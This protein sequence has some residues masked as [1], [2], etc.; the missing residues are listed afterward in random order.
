MTWVWAH[1]PYSGERLLL[2][3]ALADYANDEGICFPSHGTLARKARCSQGWVS[4]TI[5]Q[6]IGDGLLEVV[7]KAG[8][9]RGKVGRYRLLIGLTECDLSEQIGLTPTGVRSHSEPSHSSLL[10]RQEP[11]NT[12]TEFD[13][14]WKA[15]PRKTAKGQAR[16]SFDR[17]MR[18]SGAPTLDILLAA[19]ER[20]AAPF[21]S[22]STAITYCAHLATW[23]N[24]ERW[25]DD[26]PTPPTVAETTIES[27]EMRTAKSLAAAFAHTRRDEEALLVS[28]EPYS[29]AARDAALALF[30]EMKAGTR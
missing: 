3:L 7:E 21:V 1:S 4:Q 12:D 15:Y 8:Q 28:L 2:H 18:A 20:Y 14:L 24:G 25:L 6:M 30:R 17:V 11:S 9:G 5:K 23:L 10:N 22:G 29:A 16:R 27:G 13:A 26:L 19:V